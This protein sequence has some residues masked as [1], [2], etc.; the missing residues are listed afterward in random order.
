[1]VLPRIPGP[2]SCHPLPRRRLEAW[3][4]TMGR[5]FIQPLGRALVPGAPRGSQAQ[6]P[7]TDE[8]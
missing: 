1:M 4:R 5:R 2:G 8:P 7:N 3:L 6:G